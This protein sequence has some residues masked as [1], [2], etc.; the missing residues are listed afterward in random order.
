MIP[1]KRRWTDVERL[2]KWLIVGEGLVYKIA[3]V[4]NTKPL[5]GAEVISMIHTDNAVITIFDAITND[6]I[7]MAYASKGRKT[8]EEVRYAPRFTIED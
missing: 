7:G 5:T 3:I 4:P 8:L 1:Q 2:E 6:Y